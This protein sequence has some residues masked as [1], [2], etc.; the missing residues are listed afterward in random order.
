[1]A[2]TDN[3]KRLTIQ[4]RPL[5]LSGGIEVVGSVP[6]NQVFQAESGEYT[7]DYTLTP[8]VLFPRCN[9][10]NPETTSASYNVNAS[11]T[12]MNWYEIYDGTRTLIEATNAN[13]EITTEGA[14]KGTIKV[15][16][17]VPSGHVFA[18]EFYAEYVD[19][20]SSGVAYKF[21][22]TRGVTT[23]DGSKPS[24]VIMIDSPSSMDWNPIREESNQTIK[25]NMMVGDT[26]V[27]S[28]GKCKF[29]VYRK[30]D[31]GSLELVTGSGDNDWEVVS[32]TAT[33]IT[34]N[35]NL[36][37]DYN[38]YVVKASYDEGGSPASTP[39]ESI[40][41]RSTTIR[42]RIPKLECD[43]EGLPQQ[44]PS[45]T[46]SITPKPIVR[47]NKGVLTNPWSTL[48]ANW[49]ISTNNGSSFAL[50]VADNAAP[51]IPFTDGMILK[52][53]VEDRGPMALVTSNGAIVTSGGKAIIARK[54][55]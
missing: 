38:T 1:M 24:P 23:T 43:W 42:R 6:D 54:S 3:R 7:P 46:G 33:S 13:Y 51:T 31:N 14:Q 55:Y 50:S 35:R 2:L 39:D 11:L 8:L 26:D 25:F 12:N 52:L 36:I 4:T 18:L 17:N 27:T 49:Y 29:F 32:L 30:L 19:S 48:S 5:Q 15:K 40:A 9:A 53:E 45:G 10:T 47:D 41:Y 22:F 28:S 20:A 34:I 37:G 21:N 16:R 44:L